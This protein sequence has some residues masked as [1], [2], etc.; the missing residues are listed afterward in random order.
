MHENREKKE[1]MSIIRRTNP[2]KLISN[3][4]VLLSHENQQFTFK[5]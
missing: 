5:Y 2:Y 4:V 1:V 3:T